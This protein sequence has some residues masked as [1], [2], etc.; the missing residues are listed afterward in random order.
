M[1]E[2]LN[3]FDLFLSMQNVLAIVV[4][5][6]IGIVI[7]AI[8][9]L[10]SSMG[11]ALA[12]PFTYGMNPVS[13]ILLVVGIY[14]GGMFAGSISAILIRTPGTPGNICTLLDGWPL[15]QKGQSRKALDIALYSSVVAD[16]ASNLALILF[17]AT[18]ASFALQ[19]GPAEYF[20]LMTFSLTIVT[21]V[22]GDSL[23]KGLVSAVL[24]LLLATVGLDLIYGN[25]R[26]TFGMLEFSGG[27]SFVPL[28]IGLFAIPEVIDFYLRKQAGLIHGSRSGPALTW[29]EFRKCVPTIFR[30]SAIGVA[31][32]AIP[33]VGATAASFLSYSMAKRSSKHPETYGKGEIDGVAAAEAG[34]N[35]VAGATLIPLLALGIPGDVVTAVMIG[36]FLIH[37]LSIGPSLFQTQG[38]LVYAIFFGIMLSSIAML[39]L[40]M[41]S[42][43]LFARISDIPRHILMPG[44]LIFCVFGTYAIQNSHFDILVMFAAGFL[45]FF[46]MKINLPV[47]PFLIA[48]VLG[49]S[50]E[51]NLRRTILVSHG[52]YSVFFNSYICWFFAALTVLSVGYG[53]LSSRRSRSSAETTVEGNPGHS[54]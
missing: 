14:K 10:S 48:F 15:S 23:F 38:D 32:G 2:I 41:L 51:D 20:W 16:L 4:G 8:P 36:A 50:F 35:A 6:F 47:P 25:P 37:G 54:S 43:R 49:P 7:G 11:I 46:M 21:S 31:I 5:M 39:I 1:Q 44:L 27:V 29:L 30:S 18:I 53:V 19:F 12:L 9:G 13:A 28:L 24:G 22:A 45:G 40:G 17:A 34:N 42:M 33:G 26:F 52:D 3:G